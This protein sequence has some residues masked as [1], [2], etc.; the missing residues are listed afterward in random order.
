MTDSYTTVQGDLVFELDSFDG[1]LDLLL[2]LIK[3]DEIDIYDIPVA[4]I[5]RQYLG[6]LEVCKEL[7]LEVAG[8]FLYMASLLIRIKAQL[9]LPRQ[10]A[11][12]FTFTLFKYKLMH[13]TQQSKSVTLSA[14]SIKTKIRRFSSPAMMRVILRI[15]ASG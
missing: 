6:Y 7:N 12:D 8:E 10:V 14:P 3:R 4:Q 11:I 9:L 2:Y 13:S 15:C 1:P 5:T